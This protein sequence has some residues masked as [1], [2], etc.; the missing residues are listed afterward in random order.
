MKHTVLMTSLIL[1]G[2]MALAAETPAKE[3]NSVTTAPVA[4]PK[5][6]PSSITISN[7]AVASPVP[8]A[9]TLDARGLQKEMMGV[10]GELRSYQTNYMATDSE[11]KA[12]LAR[13]DQ[14]RLQEKDLGGQL[15]C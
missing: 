5:M 11:I 3:T 10:M 9:S 2:G 7:P 12:L 14:L 1:A 4:M 15:P 6:G 13:L 8:A